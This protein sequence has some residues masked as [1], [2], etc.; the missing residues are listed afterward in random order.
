L[1]IGLTAGDIGMDIKIYATLRDLVGDKSI[2]LEG[3]SELTLDQMLQQLFIQYPALRPK[4]LTSE[5]RLNTTFQ[6]LI[7]GR[8]AQYIDGLDT[9]VTATDEVRIFPPV[10]GGS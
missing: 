3:V 8:H 9:V 2:H 4:L 5:G 1:L 10:G 6:I 7:N